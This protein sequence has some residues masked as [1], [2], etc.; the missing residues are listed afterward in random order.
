[1]SF[2]TGQ[3]DL[4]DM[5]FTPVDFQKARE[6]LFPVIER[7]DS[8]WITKPRGPL[9]KFWDSNSPYA[10]CS[11]ID[12]A[13]VL[14]LFQRRISTRSAPLFCEK[15]KG[16]LH[17]ESEKVFIENLN[18]FQVGYALAHGVSP[19]DVD[20][21]VP[22]ELLLP[23]TGHRRTRTPDF[24]VHL[25]DERVF[26]EATVLHIQILDDWDKGV[27]DITTALKDHLRKK[28]KDLTIQIQFPLPFRGDAV[29][30]AKRLCRRIDASPP[31]GREIFPEG[32]EV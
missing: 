5:I 26:F 22:K 10:T 14:S 32:G 11:L 6:Y 8:S 9:A 21:Q 27:N 15:V 29:Q 2:K 31:G 18:E 20:P 28:Q 16:I 7:V 3:M 17:P 24:A 30:M 1:M 25:S 4:S 19:L 13:S 12:T 23:L